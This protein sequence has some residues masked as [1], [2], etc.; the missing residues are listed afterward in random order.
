[1]GLWPMVVGLTGHQKFSF[2]IPH[3][4]GFDEFLPP[5][6]MASS[7]EWKMDF[8]QTRDHGKLPMAVDSSKN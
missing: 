2:Q 8:K 4:S 6:A 5:M 3:G 7:G 1:M